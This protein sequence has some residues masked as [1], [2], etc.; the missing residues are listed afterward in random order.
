MTYFTF[1][2][3]TSTIHLIIQLIL[4]IYLS[5]Y[6]PTIKLLIENS[7]A[8]L[9]NTKGQKRSLALDQ[10]IQK[11][12][13]ASWLLWALQVAYLGFFVYINN[14]KMQQDSPLFKIMSFFLLLF[15][16]FIFSIVFNIYLRFWIYQ[17]LFGKSL[18]EGVFPFLKRRIPPSTPISINNLNT[19][20]DLLLQQ[21]EEQIISMYKHL[22]LWAALFIGFLS[23]FLIL[24][25][26]LTEYIQK[27]ITCLKS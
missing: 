26:Y 24:Y 27:I 23:L 1:F 4:Y 9:Q 22:S 16:P 6:K 19:S 10:L 25:I 17:S 2:I 5:S 20:P 3:I 12:L 13:I 18:T 14:I 8:L 7:Y 11:L 21:N 15:I